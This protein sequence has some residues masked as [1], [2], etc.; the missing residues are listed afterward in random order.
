MTHSEQKKVEQV[1]NQINVRSIQRLNLSLPIQSSDQELL[2]WSTLQAPVLDLARV[3]TPPSNGLNGGYRTRGIE[4]PSWKVLPL[5]VVSCLTYV[6][7]VGQG[8]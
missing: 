3:S 4:T 5:T 8:T 1:N 6:P 2:F 7:N